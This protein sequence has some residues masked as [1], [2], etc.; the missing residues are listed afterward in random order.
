VSGS[1]SPGGKVNILSG[2]GEKKDDF[3]RSSDIEL[4][5]DKRQVSK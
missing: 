2:G 5:S 4:L 3:L 1:I